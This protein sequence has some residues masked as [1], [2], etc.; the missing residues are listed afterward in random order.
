M[1]YKILGKTDEKIPVIGQ[2]CM[3]IGGDLKYNSSEDRQQIDA[4]KLGIELG[5]SLIDTA[6]VYGGGHSEEIV[7]QA[8]QGQRDKV[9][10][11][12]KFSPDNNSFEKVIQSAEDSLKRLK[13]GYIDLYQVHW[14]NPSIPIKD[15]MMALEI[16]LK[17][18]KIRFIGL[19]N[20]S[21][22]EIQEAQAFLGD[23]TIVSNQVEYNLFDRFVEGNILPYCEKEKLSLLAYSPLD[24]G[25]MAGNW[26]VLWKIADNYG[27]TAAQVALNWLVQQAPVVVIP[28]ATN[29]KHIREN[30]TSMDFSLSKSDQSMIDQVFKAEPEKIPTDSICVSLEGEGNRKVYQSLEQ[31]LENRFGFTPSPSD[32][33]DDFSRGE[34]IKPVRLIRNNNPSSAYKYDL[35]E[36]RIR[37]WA[38]V[39]AYQKV[40]APIPA[41]I[42]N[43]T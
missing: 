9:F 43:K 5:M 42:R 25:H 1:K 24:K 30:A 8:V 39:I 32:L 17:Q 22:S 19:S 41:Y 15:T 10:I 12:T 38:W 13:T 31:A 36:G 29:P 3:G 21:V 28:K 14:P 35:I 37:Y 27:K 40:K 2:G 23:A 18:G 16:L 34:T 11:A 26:E 33:A 7:G 6:A 4:L 20:F